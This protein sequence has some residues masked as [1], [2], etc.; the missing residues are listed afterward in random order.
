MVWASALYIVIHEANDLSTR[1]P[2]TAGHWHGSLF[3][4]LHLRL[5]RKE[6]GPQ[7]MIYDD[8]KIVYEYDVMER[9]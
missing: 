3:L 7:V 9:S 5:A 6:H 8:G 2:G 1:I 4:F